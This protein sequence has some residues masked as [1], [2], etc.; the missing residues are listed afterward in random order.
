MIEKKFQ[1]LDNQ[2]LPDLDDN[3]IKTISN[4]YIELYEK[5]I[6]E[7]FKKGNIENIHDRIEENLKNFF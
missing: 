1:G 5:I 3:I 6:N 2:I 7:N 4:R